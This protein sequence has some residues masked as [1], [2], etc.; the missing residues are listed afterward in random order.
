MK[1]IEITTADFKRKMEYNQ[2]LAGNNDSGSSSDGDQPCTIKKLRSQTLNRIGP[3]TKT[4]F[5]F[6]YKIWIRFVDWIT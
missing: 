4:I 2:C 1:L 6:F 5:V 3:W